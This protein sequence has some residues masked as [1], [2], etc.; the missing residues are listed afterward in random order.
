[1]RSL[2]T[3]IATAAVLAWSAPGAAQT[4]G[5]GAHAGVSLPMGDYGDVASTGFSGGVDLTFPLAMVSPA[6]SWYTSADAAAH[7]V[8]D[9]DL[10]GGFLFFPVMTGLRLDVGTLGMMRPFLTGQAGVAFT[11]GPDFNGASA[12]T[13]TQLGFALGGGLQLTPNVYA[14]AKWFNLGDVDFGYDN[15]D[16]ITQSVSYVDIYLG[17]GVR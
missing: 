17:F 3:V 5:F 15:L 2:A 1:M 16:D 6:V 13:G 14:G 9:A 11:R 12:E 7:S 4:F 8:D 10:D